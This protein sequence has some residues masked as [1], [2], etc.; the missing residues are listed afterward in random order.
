MP[1]NR[2]WI[3]ILAC[4][5]DALLVGIKCISMSPCRE[6]KL[7]IYLMNEMYSQ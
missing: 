2:L 5:V 6:L 1:L 4:P 3:K 7:F